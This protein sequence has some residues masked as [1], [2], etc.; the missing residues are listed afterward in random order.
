[1]L[2]RVPKVLRESGLVATLILP[3]QWGCE[4][5][6]LLLLLLLLRLRRRLLLMGVGFKDCLAVLLVLQIR[7]SLDVYLSVSLVLAVSNILRR[8]W[9]CVSRRGNLPDTEMMGILGVL[10]VQL[11]V[12]SVNSVRVAEVSYTLQR[13]WLSWRALVL[14]VVLLLLVERNLGKMGDA[15]ANVW[16]VRLHNAHTLGAPTGWTSTAIWGLLR[17]GWVI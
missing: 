1:L 17:L 11:L 12:R 14:P 10:R 3:L 8:V 4:L 5:V 7:W 2:L 6:L 9:R 15:G 13:G 16:R